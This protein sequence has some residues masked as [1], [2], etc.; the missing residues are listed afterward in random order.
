MHKLYLI[1]MPKNQ[2]LHSI[3]FYSLWGWPSKPNFSFL[4]WNLGNQNRYA[5][6][7]TH[8]YWADWIPYA[9]FGIF[10]LVKIRNASF[11]FCVFSCL[12]GIWSVACEF[13]RKVTADIAAAAGCSVEQKDANIKLSFSHKD[14]VASQRRFKL[15]TARHFSFHLFVTNEASDVQSTFKLAQMHVHAR[16]LNL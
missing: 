5:Q 3:K 7:R 12:R 4:I 10:F 1:K 14:L 15:D 8:T 6:S 9:L 11:E 16:K 2:H 13:H